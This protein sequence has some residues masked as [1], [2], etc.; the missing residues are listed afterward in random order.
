MCDSAEDL[1]HYTSLMDDTVKVKKAAIIAVFV[2][3]LI[4]VVAQ[5]AKF[6]F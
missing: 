5:G 1:A 2:L 4:Y 6:A 3:Y